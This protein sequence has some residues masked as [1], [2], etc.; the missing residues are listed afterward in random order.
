MAVQPQTDAAFRGGI[1]NA[2]PV[3]QS[4]EARL[5][6]SFLGQDRVMADDDARCLIEARAEIA[7]SA[8]LLLTHLPGRV[9]H[10][11]V[12]LRRVE[13][14][15]PD[16]ANLSGKGINRIA[17]ALPLLPGSECSLERATPLS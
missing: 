10:P 2:L 14:D 16:V 1:A 3:A 15:Q 7:K 8:E 6:E 13:P 11:E 5:G 9:P 12:R 17:N 4:V